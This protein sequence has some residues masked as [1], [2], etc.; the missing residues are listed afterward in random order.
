MIRKGATDNVL[1][2]DDA[3]YDSGALQYS[4]GQYT[5]THKAI[6]ADTFRYSTNFG[7]NWTDW[8]SWESTTTISADSFDTSDDW[9]QGEHIIVQ[10]ELFARGM[11]KTLT[12]HCA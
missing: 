11:L 10:C 1:V 9:W 8:Q 5:F 2:W 7:Q 3:S 12:V 4:D 6:G